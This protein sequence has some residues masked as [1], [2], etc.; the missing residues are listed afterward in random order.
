ML[1]KRIADCVGI[2][3][4]SW[5][6][7]MPKQALFGAYGLR[8][9]AADCLLHAVL[10][11]GPVT[12][13]EFERFLTCARHALLETVSRNE[14]SDPADTAALSFY[15]ALAQ[16]CY[17]NEYIFDI[18]DAE[19]IAA[20]SCRARLLALLDSNAAVPP[21]LLVAVAAYFP[22]WSLPG[23]SRLLTA[24]EVGAVEA[25]LRLQIR[26][27]LEERALRA[28][29]ECLTPITTGV[30][31]EVRSQYEQ[32]PYPRWVKIPIQ[33]EALSFN[34]ELRRTLPFAAFTPL[35]D[36]SAPEVLVAGCGTG[37]HSISTAQRFRGARV[38]AI[39]LSLSSIAYAKRKTQELGLT[40]IQYAQADILKLSDI[41]ASF[42]IIES[43]GVL[44]HLEDPFAGW[45]T[46][47]SRLRPGGFM[48]LGFYSELA[49]RHLAA[50]R[51][52]ISARGYGSTAD[53]IRRFRRDIAEQNTGVDLQRLRR[54][55]DF[56]STS[57]CRDL[58]FHV[59]E[60]CLTLERIE[61][62]LLESKL[63]FIGFESE[64]EVQSRYRAR[65]PEDA[66]AVNL[67]NWT[68]F[69]T[70]NPETF[71]GMYRFWIQKP[72]SGGR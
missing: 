65:F 43:I 35:A 56:Y 67:R 49:H 48:A 16:Q 17:I 37:S 30:S 54:T 63:E 1:D 64:H 33:V 61:S 2:A 12:T 47:L 31:E 59:Q 25:L 70:D 41:T 14:A 62:F 38:L 29:I 20:S 23:A 58:L 22:L 71:A 32:N 18:F 7:R 6:V 4:G 21:L 19:E 72:L 39:D 13:T 40:N 34:N 46:L 10:E 28:G 11:T 50:A 42:D 3:N 51:K 15:A 69:E 44:H 9:L 53:E 60:H 57:D 66:L 36:D 68:R 26:D 24:T 5:P 8:A 55:A 27:P 45:R 52:F